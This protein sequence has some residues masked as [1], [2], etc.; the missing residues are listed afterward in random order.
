MFYLKYTKPFK[1]ELARFINEVTKPR[2]IAWLF[3]KF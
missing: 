2:K 3:A 1:A